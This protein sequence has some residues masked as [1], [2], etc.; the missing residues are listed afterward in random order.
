MKS[1]TPLSSKL[2]QVRTYDKKE[3]VTQLRN[4]I[5]HCKLVS[6][7]SYSDYYRSMKKAMAWDAI[8]DLN[9]TLMNADTVSLQQLKYFTRLQEKALVEILPHPENTSYKNQLSLITQLLD[10]AKQ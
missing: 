1:T 9:K 3:F 6:I 7:N 4:Y 8:Y 10:Y 5:K 2:S